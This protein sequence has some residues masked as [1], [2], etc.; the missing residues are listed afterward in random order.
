MRGIVIIGIIV[1]VLAGILYLHYGTVEPCGIM[2]ARLRAET[3]R[4]GGAFGGL[5]ASVAT[6]S[7]I[8]AAISTEYNEPIS[9]G[10]CIGVIFGKKPPPIQ[11]GR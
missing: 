4:Q 6:D 2:R 1:A 8:D 5:L 7:V 11:T 3:V 10:L 9:P